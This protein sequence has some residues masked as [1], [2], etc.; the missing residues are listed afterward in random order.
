MA[1]RKLDREA[2]KEK[3]RIL[4]Q[5]CGHSPESHCFKRLISVENLLFKANALPAMM[6]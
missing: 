2:L 1:L 6:V 3:L 5:G 4:K